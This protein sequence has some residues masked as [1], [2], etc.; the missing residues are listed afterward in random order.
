MGQQKNCLCLAHSVQDHESIGTS[1]AI[2]PDSKK[3]YGKCKWLIQS[4]QKLSLAGVCTKPR[5]IYPSEIL[6]VVWGLE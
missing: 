4:D 5:E 3:H 2:K 6:A 1:D